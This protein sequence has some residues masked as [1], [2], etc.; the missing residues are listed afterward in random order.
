MFSFLTGKMKFLRKKL[1]FFGV[2]FQTLQVNIVKYTPEP[3][4]MRQGVLKRP[5]G[6]LYV[7]HLQ[8]DDFL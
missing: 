2:F 4:L 6:E 7:P 3:S 5:I 8:I 1:L